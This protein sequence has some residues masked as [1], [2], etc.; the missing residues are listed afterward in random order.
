[1][2]FQSGLGVDVG[3]LVSLNSLNE[4]LTSLEAYSIEQGTHAVR[5][6]FTDP[7]D[8]L[9]I[10]KYSFPIIARIPMNGVSG[11]IVAMYPI[12]SQQEQRGW[13]EEDGDIKADVIA[14]WGKFWIPI[15]SKLLSW[16]RERGL[17]N[18]F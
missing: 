11:V 9:R 17:I 2:T 12:A 18:E 3:Y 13:Y 14:D 7:S 4:I 10:I 15:E 5:I 8:K 16:R 6:T 1:M